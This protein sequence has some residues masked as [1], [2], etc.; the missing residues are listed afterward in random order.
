MT[1]VKD[2]FI[3]EEAFE[4]LEIISSKLESPDTN[5]KEAMELYKEG[6]EL[7]HKCKE[8]LEGVEKELK[9]LDEL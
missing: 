1:K 4:R 7:V 9:I 8:N 5:L 6:T 3:I 2:D